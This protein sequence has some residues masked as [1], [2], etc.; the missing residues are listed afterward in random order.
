[1]YSRF[2]AGDNGGERC[3]RSALTI[4]EYS[5]NFRVQIIQPMQRNHVS[6][7]FFIFGITV[8]LRLLRLQE[9]CC[10]RLIWCD[11]GKDVGNCPFQIIWQ[12]QFV[13]H[14][15]LST[16]YLHPHSPKLLQEEGEKS[17]S[18]ALPRMW[19]KVR[20]INDILNRQHLTDLKCKADLYKNG[21]Y[22]NVCCEASI[23]KCLL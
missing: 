20:V 3:S 5:F 7:H 18:K 16:T 10:T 14:T 11:P 4:C 6:K 17:T 21:N 13:R 9:F 23:T 2:R 8:T 19:C 12:C 15:P 1:M 22:Q